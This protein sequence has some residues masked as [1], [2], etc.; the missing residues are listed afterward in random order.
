MSANGTGVEVGGRFRRVLR[1]SVAVRTSSVWNISVLSVLNAGAG[2]HRTADSCCVTV[3]N[4]QFLSSR[5][6][7]NVKLTALS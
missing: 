3:F 1:S 5:L 2:H 4:V 6:M 7:N